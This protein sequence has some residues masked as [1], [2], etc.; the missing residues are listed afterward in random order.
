MAAGSKKPTKR[1]KAATPTRGRLVGSTERLAAKGAAKR[2]T[3]ARRRPG[4]GR[5]QQHE[6]QLGD[7]LPRGMQ[8]HWARVEPVTRTRV[9]PDGSTLSPTICTPSRVCAT[10]FTNSEQASRRS[11]SVWT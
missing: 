1:H 9:S 5:R 11:Q 3:R 7:R 2:E 4:Y 10:T 6:S 8:Q